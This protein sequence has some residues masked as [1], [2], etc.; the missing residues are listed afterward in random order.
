MHKGTVRPERGHLRTSDWWKGRNMS[1]QCSV[2]MSI[3]L[4]VIGWASV[5]Y[6][7]TP[8]ALSVY[9]L[10]SNTSDGDGSVYDGQVVDCVGGIV[11]GKYDGGKPR[12]MLQDPAN[13][14]GW[15]GIQVKD[16]TAELELFNDLEIV[17]GAWV[18]LTAVLVEES[19][20]TTVLHYKK[21]GEPQ[22]GFNVTASG[23]PL[24]P[25]ILVSVSDIPAPIE[26]PP[27]DWYVANHDA[28]LYESMRIMVRDVSVTDWDL[29]SHVDNYNIQSSSA[30]NCWVADY[31]NEAV[32]PSGYHPFV[33]PGQHFCAV[34]GLFEQF[35]NLSSG[36]DYY[37]LVTMKTADPAICGDGN[38]D[39]LVDLD[40]VPRFGE[41]L[42]GPLCDPVPGGC[43]PPGWTWPPLELPVQ[44]CLMM[45]FDYDAD[46]DLSDFSGLQVVFG[47]P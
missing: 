42:I 35:T 26:G 10:Q 15:G 32:G 31:M 33:A 20:G 22:S 37:Q 47:A 9:E 28:E 41:C 14:T 3:G 7:G 23:L 34:V 43:D 16:W 4:L 38:C 27:G 39:G 2:S 1:S 19:W 30:D 12:V 18:G 5:S 13:P 46:V 8:Q 11:V 24:P 25:L 45:D 21:P 40:D 17:P 29:G 44:H 36:W 6:A